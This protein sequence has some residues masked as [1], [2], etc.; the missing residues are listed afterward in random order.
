[1]EIIVA[2]PLALFLLLQL[3]KSKA[4]PTPKAMFGYALLASL[5]VLARLDAAFFVLL[6][7]ISL[8]LDSSLRRSMTWKHRVALLAGVSLR[9]SCISG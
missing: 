2:I 8:V 7:A 9:S 6:L 1:M 4:S 3:L 5:T